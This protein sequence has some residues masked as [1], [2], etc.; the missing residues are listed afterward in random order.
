MPKK[1]K[2]SRAVVVVRAA[3]L[4]VAHKDPEGAI[5]HLISGRPHVIAVCEVSDR[6]QKPLRSIPGYRYV[7]VAKGS[8]GRKEVGL[9]LRRDVRV[10]QWGVTQMSAH[11][12]GDKFAHDR[13]AVWARV[14]LPGGIPAGAYSTH[15]NAA[16]Q[17]RNGRLI[18]GRRLQEYKEHARR[19]QA[20]IRA[21]NKSGWPVI[22]GQDGN[23]RIPK[24]VIRTRAQAWK[25][26]PHRSLPAIN[27]AYVDHS[28]DG[29]LFSRYAFHRVKGG[30]RLIRKRRHGSDHDWL[31][32]RVRPRKRYLKALRRKA[33]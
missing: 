19:E 24:G 31:T 23:Y 14:I 8:R 28:V 16:I 21:L 6:W 12:D 33:A 27:V 7:G 20:L 9:L 11:I 15:R 13:W 25:W 5:E 2:L 18:R 3:N 26:S 22:G 17:G 4:Y 10:L 29:I 30:L 32:L 1:P